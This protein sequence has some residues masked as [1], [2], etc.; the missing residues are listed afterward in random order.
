MKILHI[1]PI[2]GGYERVTLIANRINRKNHLAAI[3]RDGE[4]ISMTGGFVVNDTPEIREVLDAIP[5]DKQYNFVRSF[6]M[7]PF[8]K[9]YLEE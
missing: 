6:K 3:Q 1:T 5:K 8:A 2:S 9:F 4:D 7:N